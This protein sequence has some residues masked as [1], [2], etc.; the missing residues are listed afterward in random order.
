M[1]VRASAR[2]VKGSAQK[3]RLILNMIKGK[4]AEEAMS[5]LQYLPSPKARII[6][7]VLKSAMANAENNFNLDPSNMKIVKAVADEGPK[8]MRFRP[9]ARGRV[10]PIRKRYS[11]ITIVLGEE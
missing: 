3:Y 10:N 6:S 7:K 1:E 4:G 2:F 5:I 11:H 8:L 9:K